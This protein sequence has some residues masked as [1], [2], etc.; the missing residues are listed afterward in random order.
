VGCA[1]KPPLF[2]LRQSRKNELGTKLGL[3]SAA[4]SLLAPT[5]R[6]PLFVILD[7]LDIPDEFG[8]KTF[9]LKKGRDLELF[10]EH[11]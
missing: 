4:Y 10:R 7:I 2:D 6:R 3:R 1:T 9:V 8:V 5:A 11:F